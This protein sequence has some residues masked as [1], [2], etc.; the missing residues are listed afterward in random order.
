MR[1][2]VYEVLPSSKAQPI[3]TA[4]MS[5]GAHPHSP[6]HVHAAWRVFAT[7]HEPRRSLMLSFRGRFCSADPDR[8]PHLDQETESSHSRIEHTALRTLLLAA[9]LRTFVAGSTLTLCSNRSCPEH[10][11]RPHSVPLSTPDDANFH[12]IWTTLAA[13]SPPYIALGK[14]VLRR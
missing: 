10:W 14:H 7:S 11:T 2:L 13:S 1:I 12:T 9:S 4:A 6:V 3:G 5:S 8:V